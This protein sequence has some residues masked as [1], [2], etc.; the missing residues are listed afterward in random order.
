MSQFFHDNGS[1]YCS[2]LIKYV[3]KTF[4]AS[5]KIR[6][7]NLSLL[8]DK[9][10]LFFFEGCSFALLSSVL[11]WSCSWEKKAWEDRRVLSFPLSWKKSST[12]LKI[13]EHTILYLNGSVFAIWRHPVVTWQITTTCLY[14]PLLKFTFCTKKWILYSISAAFIDGDTHQ[15]L[16]E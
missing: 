2:F 6:F 14:P 8:T 1:I 4:H 5:I 11:T 12:R 15:C 3:H 10:F 16:N 13:L 7:Y 9:S